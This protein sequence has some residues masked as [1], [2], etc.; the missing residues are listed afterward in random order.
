MKKFLLGVTAFF[1][2]T[3]VFASN[4][5]I[6]FCFQDHNVKNGITYLGRIVINSDNVSIDYH[7]NDGSWSG[8]N[9]SITELEIIPNTEGYRFTDLTMY[10]PN[11][12]SID[13]MNI[14]VTP[15]RVQLWQNSDAPKVHTVVPCPK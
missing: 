6:T 15:Y 1:S 10:G 11:N 4:H 13:H 12:Y 14:D 8:L 7:S 3:P 2:I 5:I 9:G